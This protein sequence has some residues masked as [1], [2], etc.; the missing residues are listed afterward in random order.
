LSS[1][2][3][4]RGQLKSNILLEL[5]LTSLKLKPKMEIT[6]VDLSSGLSTSL[7]KLVSSHSELG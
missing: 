3:D 4:S 1:E 2:D 7:G 6:F 5:K